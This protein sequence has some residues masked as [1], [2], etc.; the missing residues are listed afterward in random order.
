[1]VANSTKLISRFSDFI[2]KTGSFGS[3]E[4]IYFGLPYLSQ[5]LMVLSQPQLIY[6]Y[7]FEISNKVLQNYKITAF[8][9]LRLTPLKCQKEKKQQQ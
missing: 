6:L 9:N 1:M 4:N 5:E 8:V 3:W 2:S 7:Y